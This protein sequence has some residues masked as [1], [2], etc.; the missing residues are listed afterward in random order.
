MSHRTGSCLCGA[1][2]FKV[3]ADPLIARICWCRTCQKISANGTANA[4]FPSAAIEVTGSMSC[5][6]SIADSGNQISRHFCPGCG[7]HLFASSSATP[8][9]R[10]VRLGTLDDPSSIRPEVNMWSASAPS[11]ACLDPTLRFETQQPAPL[12]QPRP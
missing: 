5:F 7:S 8:Q 4:I 3:S 6:T 2:H 12:Q 11:W 9:F 1:V 10:V